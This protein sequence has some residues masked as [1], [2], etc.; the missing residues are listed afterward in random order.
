MNIICNII[1]SDFIFHYSY[2]YQEKMTC[3]IFIMVRGRFSDRFLFAM[4]NKRLSIAIEKMDVLLNW[5]SH[6]LNVTS[7]QSLIMVLVYS[8]T[9]SLNSQKFKLYQRLGQYLSFFHPANRFICMSIYPKV[10]KRWCHR[11]TYSLPV[12]SNLIRTKLPMYP[13]STE[14]DTN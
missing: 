12:G 4:Y 9:A 5:L 8:S 1:W 13:M 7:I 11:S 6:C 3:F 14:D 2:N 10:Q